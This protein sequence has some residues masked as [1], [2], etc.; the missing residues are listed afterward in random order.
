M[1][2]LNI[3]TIRPGLHSRSL[4]PPLTSLDAILCVSFTS[5]NSSLYSRSLC[6]P[7][8]NIA[9]RRQAYV[10][11]ITSWRIPSL[12]L[13]LS[14]SLPLSLSPSLPLSLSPSLPLS[15]YPSLP[16]S[17]SPSLP[18]SLSP[19]LPLPLPLSPSLP[20]SLSLS[21]YLYLY[22]YLSLSLSLGS[23]LVTS[24]ILHCWLTSPVTIVHIDLAIIS[25]ISLFMVLFL[26]WLCDYDAVLCLNYDA[27]PE[28]TLVFVLLCE[29]LK[30]SSIL[31]C[32]VLSRL[33]LSCLVSPRLVL[34]CGQHWNGQGW[35]AWSNLIEM[36]SS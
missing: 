9:C 20:P 31:S 28:G 33:V 4:Y 18:L 22:L 11:T 35:G 2:F 23:P 12:S 16:L 1:S 7:T 17:L 19:S 36:G 30:L 8:T 14:P 21:L 25:Y 26:F 5:Q 24:L 29:L 3:A 10:Q 34:S 13:S 27:I 6:L 32:L 15:L